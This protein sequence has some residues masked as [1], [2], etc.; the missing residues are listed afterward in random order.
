[1]RK[2]SVS[3]LLK[4]RRNRFRT[5]NNGKKVDFHELNDLPAKLAGNIRYIVNAGS[6]WQPG[7]GDPRAGYVI[8][9][10]VLSSLEAKGI[11]YDIKST[12]DK[13]IQRGFQQ[14][15]ADRLY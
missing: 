7:D 4:K 5:S 6:V 8:W 12:A 14:K 1:L 2:R 11:P 15:D 3:R 9:D 13:I 10:T